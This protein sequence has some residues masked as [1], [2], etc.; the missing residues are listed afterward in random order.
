MKRI[1]L[2]GLTILTLAAAASPASALSPRFRDAHRMHN[3]VAGKAFTPALSTEANLNQRFREARDAHRNNKLNPR[4]EEA[5]DAHRNN[6]LNPR[7]EEARDAHRN[8][9]LNPRFK[10]ARDRN[11]YN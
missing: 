10:A 7:F 4:F 9:K 11:V 3:D 2:A 8:N 6:K 5:R 1:I